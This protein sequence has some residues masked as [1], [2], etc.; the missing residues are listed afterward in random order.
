M[1]Q[2]AASH[3]VDPKELKRAQEGWHWFTML[4]FKSIAAIV[5]VLVLLA[6]ITL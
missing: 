6:W 1:H 5:V 3:D 4:V 2:S